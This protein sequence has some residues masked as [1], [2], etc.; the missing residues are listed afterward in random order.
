MPGTVLRTLPC[1][2]S[3][4]S[5]SDPISL[6]YYYYGL[7]IAGVPRCDEI[8]YIFPRSQGWEVTDQECKHEHWLQGPYFKPLGQAAPNCGRTWGKGSS[9]T[10]AAVGGLLQ[11]I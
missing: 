5:D 3:I 10:K 1:V 6:V 8:K 4:N 11:A 9:R 7:F 2:N